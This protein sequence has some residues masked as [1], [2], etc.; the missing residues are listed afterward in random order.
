[1]LV[2]QTLRAGGPLF[3]ALLDICSTAATFSVGKEP[4]LQP[5]LLS[6]NDEEDGALVHPQGPP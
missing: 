1:M 3:R 6:E 5:N 2:Q 4:R